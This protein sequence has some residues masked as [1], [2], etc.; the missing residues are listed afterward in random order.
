MRKEKV[1]NMRIE[2]YEG[3]Q[4]ERGI[5]TAYN[6]HATMILKGNSDIITKV[7]NALQEL[8][9]KENEYKGEIIH[10]PL[11]FEVFGM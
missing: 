8:R 4:T 9:M 1:I 11:D 5:P 10:N 2:L 7:M 6:K 3:L